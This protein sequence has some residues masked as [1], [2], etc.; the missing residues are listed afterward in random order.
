M[1]PLLLRPPQPVTHIHTYVEITAKKK[2]RKRK[3]RLEGIRG[4]GKNRRE[5]GTKN[6]DRVRGKNMASG[7]GTTSRDREG[8]GRGDF[9]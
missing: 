2:E 7:R 5:G 9:F 8:V 4:H 3:G 6:R 1:H